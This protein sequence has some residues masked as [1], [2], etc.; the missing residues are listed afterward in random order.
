MPGYIGLHIGDKPFR[1]SSMFGGIVSGI[2]GKLRGFLVFVVEVFWF[3]SLFDAHKEISGQ[4]ND[5]KD[6]APLAFRPFQTIIHPFI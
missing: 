6:L 1:D 3:Y 2:V 5:D 4:K